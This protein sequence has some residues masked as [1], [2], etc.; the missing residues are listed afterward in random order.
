MKILSILFTAMS[1]IGQ[2]TF[3]DDFT[4][5]DLSINRNSGRLT[6]CNAS[7]IPTDNDASDICPVQCPHIF[8]VP[9]GQGTGNFC[10]TN[11]ENQVAQACTNA[12]KTYD[13]F[14]N[15]CSQ[16]YSKTAAAPSGG[17]WG[18]ACKASLEKAEGICDM[19]K[20]KDIQGAMS[21]ANGIKN[22]MENAA[23]SNLQVAC[24]GMGRLSQAVNAG[25]TGYKTYCSTQVSDC[26]EVC[27]ND[28]NAAETSLQQ[29]R[30]VGPPIPGSATEYDVSEVRKMRSQ[31]TAL[32][33]NVAGAEEG[34]MKFMQMDQA[35][36]NCSLLTGNSF[37]EQCRKDPTSSPLCT[38][39]GATDCSNP[40]VAMTNMVCKCRA[41]PGLAECGGT[42]GTGGGTAN[43]TD[44]GSGSDT[45]SG[46]L[47]NFGGAD[48]G[49]DSG[50]IND[51]AGGE[52]KNP[53]GSLNRGGAGKAS[54]GESGGTGGRG[55]GQAGAAG[56]GSGLN[57]KIIGGYGFG[58]AAG[59]GYQGGGGSQQGGGGYN[60]GN[61]AAGQNGQRVD[62]RQF[63]PGGRMDPSRGL[64][65][66]SGPD[67][68]T[69]PN[70]D[71]WKKINT[72]Y[73][74]QSNSLL[75]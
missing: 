29:S 53:D 18:A 58:G 44:Y 10:L 64:A 68:I 74:A 54:I 39:G 40:Q 47:G 30:V 56:G 62:L 16:D 33:R 65:G 59:G 25:L 60:N 17:A 43:R 21:M 24:N 71:I 3:A 22:Q 48:G 4:G 32:N 23:M 61:P 5:L 1:L 2:S 75:P 38:V 46:A 8:P 69:G 26:T 19:N 50:M 14:S 9:A 13:K 34:L 70:S 63:L 52:N 11:N 45:T 73:S 42:M 31:C 37:M 57:A 66:I 55:G 67:G 41:N 7:Y 15:S 12:G 72:R 35:M 20:D 49:G 28:L 36:K 51:I 27:K 6:E